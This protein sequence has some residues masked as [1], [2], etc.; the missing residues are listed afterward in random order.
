MTEVYIGSVLGLCDERRFRELYER[1]PE[2]RQRKIDKI[3]FE[4]DKRLCLGA[5]LLLEQ[6]LAA[7][8]IDRASLEVACA[9]GGKPY[10]TK[11]PEVFFS[12]S[13]SGEQVMCAVSTAEVGC[14]VEEIRG[15]D[16][17]LAKRFFSAPE[18]AAI[19]A[20]PN[21]EA[22]RQMFFRLWTL[23]ES[24]MKAVGLGLA[25]PMQDFSVDPETLQVCQQV[26]TEKRYWFREYTRDPRYR[27]A[28]CSEAEDFSDA[29]TVML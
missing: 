20:C 16:L 28:C 13:H 21:E 14:D 23:K 7:R 4:K 24:F 27:Y 25:L 10:L 18:Y 22:Q 5:W 12:L 9:P 1:V 19:L 17:K 11:H 2:H 3:R 29:V 8:G 26:A 15:L 6:A